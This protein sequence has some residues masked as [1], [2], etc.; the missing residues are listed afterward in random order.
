MPLRNTAN[1][2][3]SVTKAFHWL[4]ALLILI[5]VP[6][7]LIA[8]GMADTLRTPTAEITSQYITRTAWLFSLHKTLGVTLF[9]TALARVTWAIIQPKPAPLTNSPFQTQLADT[10]QYLLY[11]TLILAPLA[12]WAHHAATTGFAPIWWPFGQSLPFI[13]KS[14][15]LAATFAGLHAKLVT[16]LVLTILLHIAGALKHQFINRD[17]TLRR[18][19]P[20]P[21]P[22]SPTTPHQ[23]SPWP[24]V[25]ALVVLGIAIGLG[26]R[27][28]EP[29]ETHPPETPHQTTSNWTTIQR[30]LDLTVT[31]FGS[32][33]TGGFAD[34][35]T[36]I[37]FTNPTGPGPAGQVVV[38]IAIASLTLG[39]VSQ[40]AMGPDYFDIERFPTARFNAK[41]EKTAT[42]YTATGPLTLR[43]RTQTITLPFD[44]TVTD[45]IALMTGT[46]SLNRLDFD[47]GA[48]SPDEN[49]LAFAV[50]LNIA[51]EAQP[52]PLR[53]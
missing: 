4:T 29:H 46:I 51:I 26:L 23:R 21:S 18:M 6:L 12:G 8:H 2:Y 13:A 11:A 10:A 25:M 31:L 37:T 41:L 52:R 45:G 30:H 1:C 17:A 36:D 9:F 44:L 33:V 48:T 43:D 27:G 40:R 14:D 49:S 38:T 15:S 42:G 20:G 24:A 19:L 53:Q 16:L 32:Q 5:L 3:G 35:S 28:H 39:S 50:D 47:I 22:Q 7:G 34:W